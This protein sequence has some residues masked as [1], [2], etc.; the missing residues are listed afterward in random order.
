MSSRNGPGRIPEKRF[1][2]DCSSCA[3][4]DGGAVFFGGLLALIAAIYFERLACGPVLGILTRPLG[5]TLGDALTKPVAHGGLNLSRIA[6]SAVL[7]AFMVGC[8]LL[9]QR[10]SEGHMPEP[11]S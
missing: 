10:R 9:T 2:P 6:S 4:F 7:A 11:A 5:A 3:S 8:I 1:P